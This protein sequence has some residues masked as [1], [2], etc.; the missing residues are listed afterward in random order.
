MPGWAGAGVGM[1]LCGYV[2][3]WHIYIYIYIYVCI[4]V[5]A[6]RSDHSGPSRGGLVPGGKS[7]CQWEKAINKPIRPLISR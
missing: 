4:Y 3:M 1:W 5:Y 2:A 6:V 7:V